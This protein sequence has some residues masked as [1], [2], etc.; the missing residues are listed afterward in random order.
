MA[1]SFELDMRFPQ[2]PRHLECYAGT[3]FPVCRTSNRLRPESGFDWSVR[4]GSVCGGHARRPLLG[5][6]AAVL[7]AFSASLAASQA[8]P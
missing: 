7:A 5:Q 3:E 4:A 6:L 8:S 1:P 2:G